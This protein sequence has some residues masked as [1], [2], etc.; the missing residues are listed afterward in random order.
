MTQRHDPAVDDVLDRARYELELEDDF[1]GDE[2]DP[3]RWIPH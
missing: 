2:L 1:D 3:S